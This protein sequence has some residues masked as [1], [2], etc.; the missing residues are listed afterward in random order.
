MFTHQFNAIDTL[1][2]CTNLLRLHI[3]NN[4]HIRREIMGSKI[5]ISQRRRSSYNFK[6]EFDI[7]TSLEILGISSWQELESNPGMHVWWFR[8]FDLAYV[9]VFVYILQDSNLFL[10][11]NVHSFEQKT[12][13]RLLTHLIK[14]CWTM[15][16]EKRYWNLSLK[17]NQ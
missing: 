5:N 17:R 13:L 2:H 1:V 3:C 8:I 6:C 15:R 12:L 10:Y 14:N 9:I 11:F 7:I 4:W 16:Y